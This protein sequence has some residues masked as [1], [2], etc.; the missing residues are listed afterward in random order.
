MLPLHKD[1][2]IDH[3]YDVIEVEGNVAPAL[4]WCVDTFGRPGDRWFM[5]NY[6]FYFRD[7]KDAMWFELKW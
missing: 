7:E 2:K 4:K 3:T 6:K 1:I 5:T